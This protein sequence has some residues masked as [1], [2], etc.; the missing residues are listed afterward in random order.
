MFVYVDLF[1][2]FLISLQLSDEILIPQEPVIEDST[3]EQ[4]SIANSTSF[5]LSITN[6]VLRAINPT[7]F[8]RTNYI[9]D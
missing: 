7:Y 9:F 2:F 4:S 1:I 5:P 6:K 8:E 3:L